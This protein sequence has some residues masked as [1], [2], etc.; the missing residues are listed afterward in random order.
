M[1]NSS[2]MDSEFRSIR[3]SEGDT[4]NCVKNLVAVAMPFKGERSDEVYRV[5]VEEC[6]NLHLKAERVDEYVGS[7]IVVRDI[8]ELIEK[9]E[10]LIFDLTGERQ[11]V[12][13]E[14]GYAHGVGN[15]ATEILLIAQE[16]TNL[17]YDIAGLRVQF[18]TSDDQL[19]SILSRSLNT[20]ILNRRPE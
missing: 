18:F 1:R 14:L 10:F 2:F 17:H 8:A 15:E 13:Y 19:R 11:N 20:M 9:A 5:I 7:G 3:Y 16:G 12:Y 4:G 6:R